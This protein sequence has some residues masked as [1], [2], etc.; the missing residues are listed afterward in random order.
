MNALFPV[1][2][3]LVAGSIGLIAYHLYARSTY[4][5]QLVASRISPTASGLGYR[6]PPSVL[7]GQQSRIPFLSLLP[8]SPESSERTR[9]QLARAGWRIR[10]GE[11]L[12]LRLACA[13]AL[14]LIAI[15]LVQRIDLP[16]GP[17]ALIAAAAVVVGWTLPRL[18]LSQRRSARL[19]RIEDQL[20]DA[21]MAVAKSLRAGS[22]LLQG[23]TYAANE[24]PDPLGEELRSTLRDLQLGLEAEDAFADLSTRVGSPD[25]DI[26]V[27]AIVI[28]RT[29]GGNLSEILSNVTETIRQRAILHREVRVLTSRQ[30]LT[31]NL[32]ALMPILIALFFLVVN[33]KMLNLLI[34]TTAGRIALAAGIFFEVAGIIMIRRFAEIE[35]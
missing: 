21:L 26:A 23:L 35:V 9:L 29:V 4:T 5:R 22:G 2:A 34:G 16:Q 1:I 13:V 14:A 3:L 6:P 30:R 12:G 28:Q 18:Y 11:F 7:R 32:V 27:T 25:L 33:P 10:A 8:I 20:P 17:R 19:K 31:S 15:V 24:T